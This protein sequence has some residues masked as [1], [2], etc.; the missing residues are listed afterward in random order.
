MMSDVLGRIVE[1]NTTGEYPPKFAGPESLITGLQKTREQLLEVAA[2]RP[3][4]I[5]ISRHLAL[6]NRRLGLALTHEGRFDE[7][8]SSL[9]ESVRQWEWVVRHDPLD[10]PARRFQAM[11][12]CDL[13]HVTEK[14][15]KPDEAQILLRRAVDLAK[16]LTAS[17][18]GADLV[19]AGRESK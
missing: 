16:E 14:Q 4:Q 3:D 5:V 1:N 9:A 10:R 13:A 12:L 8:G 11:T 17:E 18:L 7:G 15:G 19:A 6:V 2:G